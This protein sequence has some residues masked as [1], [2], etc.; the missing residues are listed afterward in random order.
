MAPAIVLLHGFTQTGASWRAVIDE[1]GERYRALAPDLRG[2]GSASA[3][4]PVDYARCVADVAAVAP[5]RFELAGYSMGARVALHVALS[6]PARVERLIL[7]GGSPGIA[8]DPERAERRREDEQLAAALEHEDDIEAFARRWA[9]QPLLR[10]QPAA[11]SAAAYEDRVRN[12]PAG[13]A[14]ALRGI[15]A[16]A[17][18]PLWGRLAELRMPVVLIVGERDAKY[19]KL[20]ERMAAKMARADVIVVPA[21]G[22]AVHMEAPA[23]VAA[24]IGEGGSGGEP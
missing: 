18:Q 16:G 10:R 21:V 13:L 2:H 20:A 4:R 7:I 8:D 17:T 12:V 19:R 24:A 3:R 15:G 14:A 9:A 6:H 11:V 22:H 1:L 23:I 5:P